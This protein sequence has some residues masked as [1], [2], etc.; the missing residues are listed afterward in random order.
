MAHLILRVRFGAVCAHACLLLGALACE[1]AKPASLTP[2][3]A[4]ASASAAVASAAVASA[5]VASAPELSAAAPSVTPPTTP[6]ELPG[7]AVGQLHVFSL[8]LASRASVQGSPLTQFDLRGQLKLTVLDRSPE[9]VLVSAVVDGAAFHTPLTEKQKEFS[10]L[11]SELKKPFLF[12]W[13]KGG[14][15]TSFYFL[16]HPSSLVAGVRQSLCA[17][18]QGAP[19]PE[20][21]WID[22]ETD[23]TGRYLVRYR[24]LGTPLELEKT[25]LS[26]FDVR[27]PQP[28][29]GRP[30]TA[31]LVPTVTRSNGHEQFSAGA[32]IHD[33]SADEQLTVSS[34]QMMPVESTTQLTL[35]GQS[36]TQ[37]AVGSLPKVTALLATATRYDELH[38]WR[39]KADPKQNDEARLHGRNLDDVLAGLRNF[40]KLPPSDDQAVKEQ[41]EQI[42]GDLYG[43]LEA[44][45]RSRPGT[46]ARLVQLIEAHDEL[47]TV[48]VDALSTAGSPQGVSATIAL[49]KGHKLDP[50]LERSAA[51]ALSRTP[52]PT[53]ES[54]SEL[55]SL[56]D[57]PEE[58]T[59]AMY[60]IG[61]SIRHLR[62]SGN[63]ELARKLLKL[64][65]DRLK[66][67]S[68]VVT[69]VTAL[70]AVANSGDAEAWPVVEPRL[71]VANELIRAAAVEALQ[72]FDHP[73]VDDAL[74]HALETDADVNVRSAALRAIHLRTSSAALTHG[75]V[76]AARSD[77]DPNVRLAAVGVLSDWA[78]S[79][80]KLRADL[81]FVSEHDPEASIRDKAKA[82]LSR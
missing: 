29:S 80:P 8:E 5:A 63:N 22:D 26:Y 69:S 34:S 68:D 31:G 2:S 60:G 64:I 15:V 32:V 46:V 27:G 74:D 42:R 54:T 44:L 23:A 33:V 81:E 71:G 76:N 82:A 45:V 53:A 3:A 66:A 12:A 1:S 17:A 10:A 16:D 30:V 19:R 48:L 72:L 21:N 40:N 18:L 39:P 35:R 73:E 20:A 25:K 77:H 37:L 4:S 7:V 67:T 49:L 36:V 56:L 58:R 14:K 38:P 61:T 9:R 50:A 52:E 59:Q 41:R 57:F 24:Q 78:V 79:D 75:V 11:D 43:G 62:D 13:G 47:S 70:R 51:I 28:T 6:L 55:V 65:V